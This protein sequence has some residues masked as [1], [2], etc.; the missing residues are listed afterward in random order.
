MRVR[1]TSYLLQDIALVIKRHRGV[2]FLHLHLG[3]EADF[4]P[5]LNK[6]AGYTTKPTDNNLGSKS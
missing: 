5:V 4:D 6:V 3:R 1:Y 2:L